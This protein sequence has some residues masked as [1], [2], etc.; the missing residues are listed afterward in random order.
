[1]NYGKPMGSTSETVLARWNATQVH[2]QIDGAWLLA[3][4]H[5]GRAPEHMP[6]SGASYGTWRKRTRRS[7]RL[8]AFRPVYFGVAPRYCAISLG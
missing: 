7:F 6:A 4:T 3:H 8:K 2:R 1:V 5:W